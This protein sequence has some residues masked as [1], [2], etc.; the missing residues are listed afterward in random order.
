MNY[1]RSVDGQEDE[2]NKL[3]TYKAKHYIFINFGWDGVKI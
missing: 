1:Y 2:S 3:T